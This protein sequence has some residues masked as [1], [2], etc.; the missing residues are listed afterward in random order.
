MQ[1]FNENLYFLFR[2]LIKKSPQSGLF[3]LN[4]TNIVYFIAFKNSAVFENFEN[5]RSSLA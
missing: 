1:L 2:L 5:S 4:I 3:L